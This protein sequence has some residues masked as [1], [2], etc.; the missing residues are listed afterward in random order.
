ML[1]LGMPVSGWCRDGEVGPAS[2]GSVTIELTVSRILEPAWGNQTRPDA[3]KEA[4]LTGPCLRSNDGGVTYNLAV[5]RPGGA[6]RR[7]PN[8]QTADTFR[9]KRCTPIDLVKTAQ[10]QGDERVVVFLPAV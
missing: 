10:L 5:A 8:L 1:A 2:T 9:S 3:G 7:L 6:L 4:A